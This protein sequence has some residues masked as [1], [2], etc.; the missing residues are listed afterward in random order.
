MALTAKTMSGEPPTNKKD[1]LKF[2]KKIMFMPLAINN[3]VKNW[4]DTTW[5][6]NLMKNAKIIDPNTTKNAATIVPKD[7]RKKKK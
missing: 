5:F 7:G 1:G 4:D 6:E 3:I 2:V